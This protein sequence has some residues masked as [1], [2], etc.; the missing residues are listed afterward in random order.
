MQ[1][2]S[3]DAAL[4]E[5]ARRAA[6]AASF[7]EA[8]ALTFRRLFARPRWRPRA[9]FKTA[10]HLRTVADERCATYRAMR[11]CTRVCLPR[12]SLLCVV[13]H[14]EPPVLVLSDS[15]HA[16]AQLVAVLRLAGVSAVH[17]EDALG[18]NASDHSAHSPSAARRALQL[19]TAF[20]L[21]RR[22]FAS[23]VS[24]FSKSA[25]LARPGRYGQDWVVDTRCF[26]KHSTDGPRFNCR[27][28]RPH[29][30]LV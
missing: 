13:R 17:D 8:R 18:L 30:D 15:E 4:R 11:A 5:R 10:V 1:A 12:E 6:R 24:T 22:R 29:Q 28:A 16:S 25:L 19:W 20:A 26:K 7:E 3:N 21:A 2:A 14:V 27:V 23:G 9:R